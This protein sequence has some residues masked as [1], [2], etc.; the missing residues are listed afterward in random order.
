LTEPASQSL[1]LIRR[2]ME[3]GGVAPAAVHA[4]LGA[5]ERLE[6]SDAG[7]IAEADI[8]PVLDVVSLE[9]LP[10]ARASDRALL[11]QLVVVKLNGGLGTGMG[12]A[13]AKSLLRVRGRETFL[14]FTARQVLALR[15]ESGGGRPAFYLMNSF[16][17]RG[18]CLQYLEKYPALANPD[19]S[20]DFVQ[21]RAPKLHLATY[22]PVSWPDDPT[23]EWCPP[24][25]GDLYAA[26]LGND[27][28]LEQLLAAGLRYAFVSNADNLGATVDLRILR[29]LED[30][31]PS[32]LME[33]ARR[34]EMDRKGGHLARRRSDGRLILRESAQCPESD[35]AAFQDVARHGL[36][37]TNN[38]WIRLEDL[39]VELAAHGGRLPLPLIRNVKPVDPSR[40]DSPRVLQVETAMGAAIETFAKSA[41]VLVPRQRFSPVKTTSDLLAVRSDAYDVDPAGTELKL[42][43]V[44]NGQP[45]QV[46]LDATHYGVLGQFEP[47]FAQG[48]PSL[49]H[50]RSLRV[51]GPVTFAAGVVI[52]GDVCISNPGAAERT[53]PPGEY[54][55]D[56]VVLG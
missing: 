25:H 56:S 43:S 51:R 53:L 34:T 5:V 30:A 49:V 42:S 31:G 44:R 39:R 20:L 3:A 7:F 19:G 36:F 4:F 27:R 29:R 22:V 55:D 37:N 32:F 47:R 14:D 28:L 16:R 9:S 17:T 33:V 21:S 52:R 41:A 13:G 15:A 23:L 40:P 46:D 10:P 50:S 12:L 8:E 35:L 2:K 26:L 54:A 1:D 48:A 45:P 18:E 38:L 11:Q 24:G 6:R